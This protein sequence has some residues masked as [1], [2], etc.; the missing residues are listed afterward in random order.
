MT[1]LL[2]E[3]QSFEVLL[4]RLDFQCLLRFSL[5]RLPFFASVLRPVATA[6]GTGKKEKS[7]VKRQG[8]SG[9]GMGNVHVKGENFYRDA[10]RV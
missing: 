3:P 2:L 6:M 8:E 10:K 5:P 9:N 4:T 7:R 1:S